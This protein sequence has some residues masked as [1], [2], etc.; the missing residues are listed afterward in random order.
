MG[1]TTAIATI[2]ASL[3]GEFIPKEMPDTCPAMTAA[4][5]NPDLIYKIAFIQYERFGRLQR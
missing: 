4:A 2:G 1:T 3:G 5:E